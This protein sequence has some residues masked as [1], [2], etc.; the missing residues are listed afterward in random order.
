MKYEFA[1]NSVDVKA[2]E[3]A[4]LSAASDNYTSQPLSINNEGERSSTEREGQEEEE[5]E[6][7]GETR[8][9]AGV[10]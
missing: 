8:A 3:T 6:V 4:L 9:G 2:R 1:W 7:G 5:E 10:R